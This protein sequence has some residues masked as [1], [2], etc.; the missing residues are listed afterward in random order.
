MRV[1]PTTVTVCF[2]CTRSIRH[3]NLTCR[4]GGEEEE[5]REEREEERKEMKKRRGEKGRGGVGGRY[6]GFVCC[7]SLSAVKG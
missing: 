2:L 7:R 1:H 6:E 5:E 3:V 4:S